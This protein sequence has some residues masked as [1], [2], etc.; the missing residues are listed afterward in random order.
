[1]A[2]VGDRRGN[3]RGLDPRP[4]REWQDATGTDREHLATMRSPPS[5]DQPP[6]PAHTGKCVPRQQ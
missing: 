6:R 1:M 5:M 2:H 4:S 3:P